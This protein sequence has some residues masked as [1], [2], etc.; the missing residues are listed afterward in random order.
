MRARSIRIYLLCVDVLQIGIGSPSIAQ[1]LEGGT[2]QEVSPAEP[3]RIRTSRR[4]LIGVAPACPRPC[5]NLVY[6]MQSVAIG[7]G[8]D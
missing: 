4:A 3:W 2:M 7:C 1:H 5:P 6:S 8:H